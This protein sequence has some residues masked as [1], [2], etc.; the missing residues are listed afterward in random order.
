MV[1]P[2]GDEIYWAE[3][4]EEV[5]ECPHSTAIA[6]PDKA[7]ISADNITGVSPGARF[8]VLSVNLE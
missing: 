6:V 3:A 2:V 7:N 8:L 4:G 5:Q 1:S